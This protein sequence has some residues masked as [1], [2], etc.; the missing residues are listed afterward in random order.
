MR[1][2]RQ[3]FI[4]NQASGAGKKQTLGFIAAKNATRS[5]DCVPASVPSVRPGAWKKWF[6]FREKELGPAVRKA[7]EFGALSEE[8]AREFWREM[9]LAE[10]GER[11]KAAVA[12]GDMTEEE[13]N[14]KWTEIT[15]ETDD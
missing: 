1:S 6:N 14:A 8:T 10:T 12:R 15:G 11:I 9:E 2:S 3:P 7:V 5:C 13:A 4:K